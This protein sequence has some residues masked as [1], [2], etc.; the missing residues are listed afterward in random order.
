M[1]AGF[2]QPIQRLLKMANDLQQPK[3]PLM[4]EAKYRVLTQLC[5]L[6]CCH[7]PLHQLSGQEPKLILP[8]GHSNIV[9]TA[10]FSPDGKK[11]VTTSWDQTAKIWD[12]QTGL[13][14]ADLNGNAHQVLSACFSPDGKK[15]VTVSD[16]AATIWDAGTGAR[17]L[18]LS[19]HDD[20]VTSA[21]FFAGSGKL[22]TTSLDHHARIWDLASGA[23]LADLNRHAAPIKYAEISPGDA[24]IATAFEDNTITIWNAATGSWIADFKDAG[25][26]LLAARFS[27]DGRSIAAVSLEPKIWDLG[28]GKLMADFRLKAAIVRS[29]AFSPDGKK[30]VIAA[31]HAAKVFDA[32]T[33]K[34]LMGL[35]GHGSDVTTA[36]FSPDG[37]KLLT[38]STDRTA[39]IWNAEN[40]TCLAELK[41][42]ISRVLMAGF[43]PDG[44]QV[45]TASYDHTAKIWDAGDGSMLADLRSHNNQVAAY[46]SPDGSSIV[47]AA[48]DSV[49][50]R[51]WDESSGRS[52]AVLKGHPDWVNSAAFAPGGKLLVTAATECEAKVWNTAS[53]LVTLT[54]NGH[55]DFVNSACFSRD[56]KRIITAS[57]DHTAKLWEASTGKLVLNLSGHAGNVTSA[58]FSPDGSRIVTSSADSSAKIWDAGS[59]KRLADLA[60][61]HSTVNSASFSCDGRL[62]VTASDDSTAKIWSAFDGH[63]VQSLKAHNGIVKTAAFSPDGRMIVTASA[64]KTAITWDV[65]TGA[66]I[67][68]LAGHNSPVDYACFSQD[69]EKVIT[70]A[71]DNSSCIW[72]PANGRLMARFFAVDSNDYFIQLPTGHYFCT[73]NASRLLHYADKDLKLITFEQLDVK[74]NRPDLVLTAINNA[75]TSLVYSYRKAWQKRISRLGFDTALFNTSLHVPQADLVNRDSIPSKQ[76]TATVRIRLIA[77]DDSVLLDRYNVWINEVPLF[78]IKGVS[79]KNRN[80]QALDT[81]LVLKLSEGANRIEASVTNSLGLESY[82]QPLDVRYVGAGLPPPRLFFIGMGIDRFWDSSHNLRWS[83][84]DIRDLSAGFRQRYGADC[85]I[86]TLF[87]E[88]VTRDKLKAL[89][90]QLL[91]T[92]ENDLVIIA[93]SGHGILNK[94]FDYF[95]STYNVDFGNPGKNG[96]PYEALEDLLDNIPARKKLLLI[97]ACHSGEVDKEELGKL[98]Q[99]QANLDSTKKGVIVLMDTAGRKLGIKNSFELMQEL[100][101]NVGRSTGATVI[102]AAAGTQFALERGDLKNGVFTYAILELMKGSEKVS[103]SQLKSYVNRRV[104]ELTNGMQVPTSRN[105]NKLIDW[106]LW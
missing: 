96:M 23:L 77:K 27:P 88:A 30:L 26:G 64:D 58:C 47:T 89:K 59:G 16:S 6:A 104:T 69:G 32:T 29:L 57:H 74:Y 78:G 39:R 90:R 44:R 62:I 7:L 91:E 75:D 52:L 82:R 86:D 31:D 8:I 42:H 12:A 103:V 100:F 50:T 71:R 20:L 15:I 76:T 87:N 14:L 56:G 93:Y 99:V 33:G 18:K 46:Y 92:T 49:N 38:A 97:D 72:T 24:R 25:E 21:C 40:G 9:N 102:S 48:W 35:K 70:A 68:S 105:E 63:L 1:I 13:L 4:Y 10:V 98:V 101:V 19:T 81:S 43:S 94:D 5:L 34:L 17:L 54:L 85:T 60:G 55:N 53:G 22:V 2:Q 41:G 61:H 66:K 106:Q 65:L 79:L 28:S 95:L 37:S 3:H 45:V 73:S 11:L 84:K 80:V 67:A 83:V 36:C 51:L